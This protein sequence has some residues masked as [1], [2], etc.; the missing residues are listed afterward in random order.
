MKGEGESAGVA[1]SRPSGRMGP[2]RPL[3]VDHAET[4]CLV[5]GERGR[6]RGRGSEGDGQGEGGLVGLL[7]AP[8]VAVCSARDGAVPDETLLGV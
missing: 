2:T 5:E 6:G 1:L 7:L 8:T 4:R 3:L